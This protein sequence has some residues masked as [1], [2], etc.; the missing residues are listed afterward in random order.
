MGALF[1]RGRLFGTN[2]P[3]AYLS[4]YR[5]TRPPAG[6]GTARAAAM[7]HVPQPAFRG[8]GTG[9]HDESDPTILRW[10]PGETRREEAA[11]LEGNP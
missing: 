9:Y 2:G 4:R 3:A 5:S 7:L 6:K 10:I 8:Q 11:S 1:V